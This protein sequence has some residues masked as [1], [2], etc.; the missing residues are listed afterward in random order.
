MRYVSSKG[1]SIVLEVSD[2][3]L[4]GLLGIASE[5][6]E[7]PYALSPEE[8]EEVRMHP[9]E[10]DDQIL[11]GLGKAVDAYEVDRR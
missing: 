1:S 9:P 7:G 4:R 8:W 3:E 10:L 5:A 6:I 11:D 2:E